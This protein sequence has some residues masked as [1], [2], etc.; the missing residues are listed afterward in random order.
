MY[1][2]ISAIPRPTDPRLRDTDEDT[3]R[4]TPYV[5]AGALSFAHS[6][7][8]LI[9]LPVPCTVALGTSAL[10]W[11]WHISDSAIV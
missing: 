8:S 4:Y 3:Y 6:E 11:I 2:L 10:L 5:S 7:S 1:S 9:I